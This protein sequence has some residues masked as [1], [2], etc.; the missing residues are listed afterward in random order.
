MKRP[1]MPAPIAR[2]AIA[3]SILCAGGAFAAERVEKGPI[4]K[5]PAVVN[6]QEG[7][8]VEYTEYVFR[9][10]DWEARIRA[11]YEKVF[12]RVAVTD[13]QVKALAQTA[14]AGKLPLT[15]LESQLV[16]LKTTLNASAYNPNQNTSELKAMRARLE[17]QFT[18]RYAG[19]YLG[20]NEA[21]TLR[22]ADRF[23][24][25]AKAIEGG[26]YDFS[27]TG[28]TLEG[29]HSLNLGSVFQDYF[30][31]YRKDVEV[32]GS[33][34]GDSSGGSRNRITVKNLTAA[35]A[36]EIALDLYQLASRTASPIAFDLNHDGKIGVTGQSS[37][38]V[39]LGKNG[40]VP[41]GSVDFDL[42]GQGR[43]GRYEWLN[44]DGDGFLVDDRDGV[45]TR[46]ARGDGVISGVQ[47]F[48]NAG[49]YAH[50][51]Q[52]LAANFDKDAKLAATSTSLPPGYGVLKGDELKG[53]L[54][55]IDSNRDAK[56]QPIE[57]RTLAQ[58]EITEIGSDF[59]M[60]KNSD[61]E[62]LMRSQYIVQ[63][64]KKYLSEDVWFAQAPD[65][66]D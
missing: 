43:T 8:W 45:V 17:T 19:D 34:S 50:G 5:T 65:E 2:T 24:A 51:F 47:L 58:L 9:S 7:T 64:G 11:L 6:G 26:L 20:A 59:A 22:L 32:L 33:H 13:A 12:G 38:K 42:L 56:V 46:A 4:T 27:V 41:E 10:V 30:T 61:G 14:R 31:K 62:L 55:W 28:F 1:G 37:A 15:T 44:G 39:R 18:V 23:L 54:V 29:Q 25:V 66:L 53:L 36:Y 60:V 49:G 35:K 57:L 52:K 48:G 63:H 40:F 16:S 21:S 3:L